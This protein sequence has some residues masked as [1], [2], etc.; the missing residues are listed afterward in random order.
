MLAALR[1]NQHVLER[2]RVLHTNILDAR[3]VALDRNWETRPSRSND[4]TGMPVAPYQG[5]EA[6]G[7]RWDQ[8]SSGLP[9][10]SHEQEYDTS[11]LMS[12][13]R[14]APDLSKDQDAS[15]SPASDS[16]SIEQS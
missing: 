2:R 3:G 12:P 8:R 4:G 6:T 5:Y 9:P 16:P 7:L 14:T 15:Q 13:S 1:C 10:L 11:P